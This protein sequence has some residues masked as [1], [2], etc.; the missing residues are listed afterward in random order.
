MEAFSSKQPKKIKKKNNMKKDNMKWLHTACL[1]HPKFPEA[2]QF[3]KRH[4][5]FH[6][7]EDG[8][9]TGQYSVFLFSLGEPIL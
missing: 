9:I 5:T 4:L 7:H 6:R 1:A 8:K 3:L 2:L